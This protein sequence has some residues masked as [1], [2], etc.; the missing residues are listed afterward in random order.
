MLDME[1]CGPDMVG[2]DEGADM[3]PEEGKGGRWLSSYGGGG[4]PRGVA[5]DCDVE[6]A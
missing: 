3:D 2:K 4:R 6:G 5:Y 1:L